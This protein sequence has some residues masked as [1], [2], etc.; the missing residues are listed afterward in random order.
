MEKSKLLSLFSTLENTEIKEF[1]KYLEGTTYRKSGGLFALFNYL[2][3]WHPEFPSKKIDKEVVSKAI[4]KGSKTF[5]RRLFDLMSNLGKLLEDFLIKKRLEQQ[6]LERDFLLLEVLKERKQ[7]K[8]FFQKINQLEKKWEKEEEAGIEH[9]HDKYRLMQMCF[10][11]PNYSVL[12]EMPLNPL[13]LIEKMDEYYFAVKL[14]WTLCHYTTNNYVVDSKKTT[15]RKEHLL[16]EVLTLSAT[17][18]FQKNTRIKLLSGLLQSFVEKDYTNYQEFKNDFIQNLDVYSEYEKHDLINF[19][20]DAC[21]ENYKNGD[22]NALQELFEIN[23]IAVEK[24]LI[25]EDGYVATG[26]FRNIVNIGLAVKELDWTE[27]FIYEFGPFLQ[28]EQKEDTLIFSEA[29]LYF[30]KENYDEALKKLAKIKLQN[31]VYGIQA[32]CLQLKCYY[33]I[34]DYDLFYNLTKSFS[35]FL[36][37]NKSLSSGIKTELLNFIHYTKRLFEYQLQPKGNLD[38]L[39]KE[40][41]E[42]T[43]IVHKTWLREKS[44]KR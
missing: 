22:T 5:N 12:H 42:N 21:Y 35:I 9:L 29:F 11:H 15:E 8:L 14:Y 31:V 20:G 40:I 13:H 30:H 39:L 16:E 4:F 27:K 17:P 36:N 3:K 19:L 44:R 23:R 25:L 28:E 43:S 33:A 26:H 24:K 37:R 18:T 10:L 41:Q 38:H 6:E 2:K 7:D 34:E 32:R 1:G